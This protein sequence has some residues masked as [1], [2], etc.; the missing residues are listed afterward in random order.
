MMPR[1][2]LAVI[3]IGAGLIGP[4]A[5]QTRPSGG[6][7]QNKVLLDMLNQVEGVGRQVRELRG[8]VEDVSNR[9][10]QTNDRAQ[11]AEKRQG[12]L[13][14]DTDARMRRLEQLAK[15]EV[16]ERKKLVQQITD[17][18]LRLK[19][20]EAD[21]EVQLRKLEADHEARFRKLEAA[22]TATSGD[23]D[24]RLKRL[25]QPAAPSRLEAD[26][27]ARLKRI[28]AADVDAR[29]RRLESQPAA[30]SPTLAVEPV[31]AA[32]PGSKPV[33]TSSTTPASLDP[34]SVGRSYDQALAKQRAGDAAGAIQGFQTFLKLYPRHELAPNA[35]YWL[36][37]AYY[38]L[39]DYANAIA[40]QQRLLASYPDHLKVPDAMLILSNSQAAA[41]DQPAARKTLEDLVAKH[42][43]SEAAEK[44]KQRLAKM[45]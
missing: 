12:D 15:D 41:G 23:F 25:E 37:E 24:T 32:A 30:S 6:A 2:L 36:G 18:E 3:A 38:R 29:L 10:E 9:V 14:N 42:P 40:T 5:A 11:K 44:A 13:Y 1:V 20:F 33:V 34:Q 26:L 22:S 8:Q 19:K 4:A 35:Q 21:L 45:R 28:E 27:E 31:P 39:G 7:D 17:M 43:L 16:A